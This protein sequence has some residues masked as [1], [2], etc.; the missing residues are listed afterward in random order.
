VDSGADSWV[1]ADS[2]AGAAFRLA[3]GASAGGRTE[4]EELEGAPPEEWREEPVDRLAADVLA[5]LEPGNALAATSEKTAVNAML[6]AIN[7]R[8]TR[9]SRFIA[10]SRSKRLWLAVMK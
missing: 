1:G 8:L 4:P 2:W 7:Q 6:A 10:A 5:V 9:C 3:W